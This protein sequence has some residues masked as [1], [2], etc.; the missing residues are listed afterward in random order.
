[1]MIDPRQFHQQR[2]AAAQHWP[3]YTPY[4]DVGAAADREEE[5]AMMRDGGGDE[6]ADGPLDEPSVQQY[7]GAA[8]VVPMSYYYRAAAGNGRHPAGNSAAGN[9][10]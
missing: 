7:G 4:G 10:Y 5:A 1:M 6:W 3:H 9:K 8:A 2:L